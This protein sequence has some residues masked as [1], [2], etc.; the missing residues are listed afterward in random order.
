MKIVNLVKAKFYRTDT[1]TDF[2]A[3][4]SA[5][6]LAWKSACATDFCRTGTL[7]LVR[8]S[9]GDARMYIHVYVY[10]T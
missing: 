4:F 2:L 10:C 8:M 6:I 3:D 5:R 1:N 7:F 9:V